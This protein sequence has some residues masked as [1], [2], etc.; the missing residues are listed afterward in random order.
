MAARLGDAA[1]AERHFRAAL[2]LDAEDSYLIG[3]WADFLLDAG[4]AGEAA[5]LL[6]DRT[7]AD[8]LLLRYA[9]ALKKLGDADAARQGAVLAARFDAAARR[10][11]TVHQREQA[12]FELAVRGDAAAAVRLARLN[13][14]VQ[15]EPADLRILAEAALA[16]SDPEAARQVRDWLARSALEDRTLAS[17]WTQPEPRR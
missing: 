10:G 8:A 7:R 14:A 2:A 13:W 3:A 15:K 9:I 16:S 5:R 12:R 11:D 6:Q 4:R 1:A 17:A